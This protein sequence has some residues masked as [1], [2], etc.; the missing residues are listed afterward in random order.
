MRA[1]R[2]LVEGF[3]RRMVSGT[4]SPPTWRSMRGEGGDH[5][6]AHAH[7]LVT[8]RTLGRAGF[9]EIANERT[10]TKKVKGRDKA[11]RDC[12]ARGH[13]RRAS[14][15]EWEQAV[16]RAYEL[17]GLDI[18]V[19]HRSHKDRGIEA[20]PTKHLGPT[21]RM[22]RDGKASERGEVNREIEKQNAEPRQ[23]C[24]RSRSRPGSLAWN[25]RASVSARGAGGAR[26][27]ARAG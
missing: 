19:D 15:Q 13:A 3:A 10:I 2:E 5:R 11:N 7:I 26:R 27:G 24:A 18:R 8:H 12:R 1:R 25:H 23:R 6:N 17:A 16:N 20:E 14:R 22:E 9:G 4:A 21:A